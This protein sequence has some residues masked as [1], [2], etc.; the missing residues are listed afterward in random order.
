MQ[1][2]QISDRVEPGAMRPGPIEISALP[3]TWVNSNPDT[4][5]IARIVMSESDGKLSVE[6]FGIG[7]QGLIEWGAEEAALFA[8]SPSSKICAGFTCVYDFGFAETKLEGMI[9][10][11]LLVLAQFHHFKDDSNRADY[12]VREYFSLIHGRY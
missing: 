6:V 10:K 5:G 12:F 1:F 8:S 11:G 3:G 9:M 7:P 4:T 2:A